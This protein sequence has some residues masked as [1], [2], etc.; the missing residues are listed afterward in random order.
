[1]PNHAIR[2]CLLKLLDAS[3]GDL[4]VHEKQRFEVAHFPKVDQPSVRD[5]GATEPQRSQAMQFSQMHQP[6]VGNLGSI[7]KQNIEVDQPF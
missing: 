1:M 3:I 4:S 2:Q 7:E 5:L 6:G